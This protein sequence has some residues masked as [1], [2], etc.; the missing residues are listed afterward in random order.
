MVHSVEDKSNVVQLPEGV[1]PFIHITQNVFLRRKHKK[2]KEDDIAICQCKYD[3]SNPKSACVDRCLNV[4]TN[5]ECTPGYCQCGD[6]CN[7][8]MF[9][10]REYAKTKLFRTNERGWGLLADENIK[11]GQFIIE[12]CGE[13]ISS[14]AAKKRS[15]VYEAHEVKETY[16]ISLDTNYVIDST[17]KGN[18]SRFLNHSCRPNCETRKWTV[19]GET[20][21]G[22]FAMK[23][24]SV[25]KELTI[26][27]YFEWYAG[28]TVR[29]LCGAANCC[30]FLGAKSQRFKEYNHVWKD[31]NDRY[32][33]EQSN[34]SHK[35][36]NIGSGS[37]TKMKS[38]RIP[39]WKKLRNI[40]PNESSN[41]LVV[42]KSS[43]EAREEVTNYE[44][45]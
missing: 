11:A 30:I 7:N 15:Y 8:Q 16:M 38:Q 28:A 44:G 21:L 5:T 27:Y 42:S 26:N 17:R 33:V 35:N 45:I 39:K 12:Y 43:K 41:L 22:I 24:I 6:S 9:Q 19:L 2:L 36:Y 40:Y 3:T 10:Q 20:R 18:F 25:G 31:G 1:T 29:C 14:E 23:D 4:L 13:V 37:T 32:K 34:K